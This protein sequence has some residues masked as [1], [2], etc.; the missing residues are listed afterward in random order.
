MANDSGKM[1]TIASKRNY[2]RLT[3]M[4]LS[5]KHPIIL[6]YQWVYPLVLI[7]IETYEVPREVLKNLQK[8][9][10]KKVQKS[11]LKEAKP[12]RDLYRTKRDHSGSKGNQC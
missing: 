11:I 4:P 9:G 1:S 10:E 6:L 12:K 3:R 8:K 5:L 2:L 7:V